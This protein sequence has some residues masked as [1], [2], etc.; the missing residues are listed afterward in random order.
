VRP[1]TIFSPLRSDCS[2]EWSG[3]DTLIVAAG[4]SALQPLLAVAGVEAEGQSILAQ[5]TTEGIQ[6]ASDAASAAIRGNYT[7]P[8][9]AA[10]TFVCL[11]STS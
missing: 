11:Y 10:V 8:L 6:R 3:L 4:V 1:Q 2:I 9:V 7:G 5:T